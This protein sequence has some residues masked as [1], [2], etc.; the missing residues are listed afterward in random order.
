MGEK[1]ETQHGKRT[2]LKPHP[3]EARFIVKL[4][5]LRASGQFSDKE[6]ASKLNDLGYRGRPQY[7][8][9]KENRNRVVGKAEGSLLDHKKALENGTQSNLCRREC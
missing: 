9:S 5:E 3:E 1:V 6:I 7:R 4:F 8:R 2:I